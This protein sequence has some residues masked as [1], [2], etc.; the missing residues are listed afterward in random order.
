MRYTVKRI[1]GDYAYLSPETDESEELF[2]ALALL[3]LG[4]DIGTVLS[5]ENLEF[6]V[7]G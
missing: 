3:P 7:E 1:E 4:V 6:T 5:Y 2:I